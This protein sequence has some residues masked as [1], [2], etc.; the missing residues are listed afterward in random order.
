[1]PWPPS[2]EALDG[3]LSRRIA[4]DHPRVVDTKRTGSLDALGDQLNAFLRST[5]RAGHLLVKTSTTT[6]RPASHEV[7]TGL[8]TLVLRLSV[9]TCGPASVILADGPAHDVPSQEECERLGWMAK[10]RELG[11][12]VQDLN[13]D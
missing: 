10:V 13:R 5:S 7:S 4:A 11:I 3:V 12:R 6:N 2:P 1:M 8:L 9:Q